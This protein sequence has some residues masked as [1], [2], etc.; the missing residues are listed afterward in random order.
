MA[1]FVVT[2][3]S[4]VQ[5]ISED[6][7]SV[8]DFLPDF[9]KELG[10]A[11]LAPGL[12]R[13]LLFLLHLLLLL[14][15]ALLELLRL[16]LVS[17]LELLGLGLIGILLGQ[18]L[19]VLL[20]FLLQLLE[21]LILVVIELLLLLLVFLV[22]LGIAGVGRSRLLVGR[23]VLGV[24]DGRTVGIVSRVWRTIGIDIGTGSVV[25][26]TAISWRFIASARFLSGN[27]IGAAK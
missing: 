15:M 13:R 7:P 19:V 23:N 20:L 17:L 9:P 4:F 6:V 18:A 12:M 25:I 11:G 22:Q 3:T 16:L 10:M 26:G 5:Q 8:P 24:S 14:D 2:Q 21:L 1:P 27:N